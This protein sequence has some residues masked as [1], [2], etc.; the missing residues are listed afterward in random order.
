ML[1][2]ILGAGSFGYVLCALS[3]GG[4]AVSMFVALFVERRE[5]RR[6]D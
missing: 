3:S 2:G 5:R 1:A 4:V 6:T